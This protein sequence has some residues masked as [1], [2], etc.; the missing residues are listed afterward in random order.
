[1]LVVVDGI[2]SAG[3]STLIKGLLRRLD[4]ITDKPVEFTDW[5]SSELTGDLLPQWKREGRLGAHSLLLA[6][7]MDLAHR[8][9]KDIR[10][11]LAEGSAVVADRYAMSGMARGVVRGADPEWAAQVFAF[12]PRETLTV[13]VEC[14]A[15]ETLRRRKSLGKVLGGYHSG[16]DFRRTDSVEA[17]FVRYQE[18][19]LGVYRS[20]SLSRGPVITVD[21]ERTSTEASVDQVLNAL[22]WDGSVGAGR[23]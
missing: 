5:N 12:A 6:E 15:E 2:Y 21:S 13:L 14:S 18:E 20:L 11:W 3:K 17:D 16:R 19:M 8:C 1:M 4:E 7:A 10:P 22:A 23:R 9:E